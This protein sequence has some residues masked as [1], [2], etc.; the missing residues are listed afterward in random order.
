MKNKIWKTISRIIL[1]V[2]I[3]GGS[4]YAAER[5]AG[6]IKISK[7]SQDYLI[8]TISTFIALYTFV[9]SL[10]SPSLLSPIFTK[11]NDLIPLSKEC[12]DQNCYDLEKYS[13]ALK[14]KQLSDEQYKE[15]VTKI[16]ERVK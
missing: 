2:L 16:I 11:T 12:T 5:I 4:F 1:V 15:I 14:N 3:A 7:D 10:F 6:L 13:A 8:F 9:I